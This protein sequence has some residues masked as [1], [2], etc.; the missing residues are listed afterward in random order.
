MRDSLFSGLLHAAHQV[1]PQTHNLYFPHGKG[2]SHASSPP[3]FSPHM[4][5]DPES[6]FYLDHTN[7]NLLSDPLMSVQDD[8]DPATGKSILGLSSVCVISAE[9]TAAQDPAIA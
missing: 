7:E 1:H 6:I 2:T 3:H 9:P 8:Q 5:S 4:F